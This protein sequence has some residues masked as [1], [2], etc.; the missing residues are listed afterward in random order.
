[1]EERT[2]NTLMKVQ[3][4]LAETIETLRSKKMNGEDLKS[5]I[6]YAKAISDASGKYVRSVDVAVRAK[7]FVGDLTR[8]FVNRVV[9][10]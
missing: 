3:N 1:M 8:E 5:E 2:A 10:E 4:I 7:N 6:D 9:G